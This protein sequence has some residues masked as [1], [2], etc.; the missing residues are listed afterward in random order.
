MLLSAGE[1][2]E[3][4][5]YC[6][7]TRIHMTQRLSSE[8]PAIGIGLYTIGDAAT[9]LHVSQR[10]IRRWL[11]GYSY[12]ARDGSVRPMQP[13]WLPQLPTQDRHIELGFRDLI[14]LRFVA[15][16]L[17]KGL[18]ILTIRRCLEHARVLVGDERPFSTRRF[19]TDGRTIFLAFV[20]RAIA[21]PS[22]VLADVPETERAR[23]IDLKTR[24]YVFR[25]VI[26][27]TFRD[28]DLDADAV[29]RW[30]PYH[31]KGTIVIDP[32]RAFGQPIAAEA[33]VPTKTIADAVAAEGS[34]KRVAALFNVPRSVVTDA[35]TFEK[36]LVA[37]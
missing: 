6:N 13:L 8:S 25:E 21:N 26:Q 35:V 20:E 28:L 19:H 17:D 34:E 23:L 27:Q 4:I 7:D 31:G 36:E 3:I 29:V 32:K 10:N 12:K 22:Q 9:L 1:P 15:A 18:G 5:N 14:E 33:G 2:L 24:Q 37:A 30:R 11:G 16:F